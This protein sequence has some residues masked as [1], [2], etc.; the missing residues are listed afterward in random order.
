M[1]A[2]LIE[3][4]KKVE[5]SCDQ[6]IAEHGGELDKTKCAKGFGIV[7]RALREVMIEVESEDSRRA[8]LLAPI[9]AEMSPCE[10]HP[11]GHPVAVVLFSSKGEFYYQAIPPDSH[12]MLSMLAQLT[13]RRVT[14]TEILDMGLTPAELVDGIKKCMHGI[15]I[16]KASTMPL[17][18]A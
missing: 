15:V 1:K 14:L 3:A 18:Q 9:Y 10:S 7:A 8:P 11:E 2:Q 5:A 6:F 16:G 12:P 4:V 17:A 13:R